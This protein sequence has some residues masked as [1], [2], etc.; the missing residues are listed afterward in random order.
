MKFFP[1]LR[2]ENAIKYCAS[3]ETAAFVH[4]NPRNV[5]ETAKELIAAN[6]RYLAKRLHSLPSLLAKIEKEEGQEALN[7]KLLRLFKGRYGHEGRLF[8]SPSRIN[9]IGEHIDYNGGLVLRLL[10]K[11]APMLL[12]FL[13]VS[14]SLG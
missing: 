13:M 14:V 2:A 11:S 3:S 7:Q 9:I 1:P 4:G 12:L 8:F 5:E 10:L 6:A